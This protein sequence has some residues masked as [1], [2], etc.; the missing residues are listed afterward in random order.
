MPEI[1]ELAAKHPAMKP[2]FRSPDSNTKDVNKIL[3]KK[4]RGIWLQALTEVLA[5]LIH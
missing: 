5:H 3:Q 4:I 2:R 1:Q